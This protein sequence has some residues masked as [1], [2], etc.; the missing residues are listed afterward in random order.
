[1]STVEL[2]C[3]GVLEL[4][5]KGYGFLRD[6]A[7][8]FKAANNDVYVGGPLLARLLNGRGPIAYYDVAAITVGVVGLALVVVAHLLGQAADM[9]AELDEIV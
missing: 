1:M 2:T 6:P 4:H 7:R 5:P 9:R 8:N 3:S